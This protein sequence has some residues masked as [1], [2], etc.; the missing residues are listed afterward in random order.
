MKCVWLETSGK[1]DIHL[2]LTECLDS[3]S[4]Q[5]TCIEGDILPVKALINQTNLSQPP[6]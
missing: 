6:T 1:S 2:S 4:L 5:S 3:S